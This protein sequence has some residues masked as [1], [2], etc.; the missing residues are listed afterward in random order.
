MEAFREHDVRVRLFPSVNRCFW[1]MDSKLIGM[2][3]S[4]FLPDKVADKLKALFGFQLT[5]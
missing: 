3:V 1:V 4:D 5:R 2:T